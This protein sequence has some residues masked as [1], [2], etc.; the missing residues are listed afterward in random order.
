[1]SYEGLSD[2]ER[3][4]L[5]LI[6]LEI[7]AA[8]LSIFSSLLLI[9]S[10]QRSKREI[11]SGEDDNGGG[12]LGTPTEEAFDAILVSFISTLLFAG[13]SFCRLDMICSDI[14]SGKCDQSLWPNLAISL[15]FVYSLIGQVLKYD[16]VV[17]RMEE[18]ESITVL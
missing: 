1:M 3:E 14:L 6:D 16:G 15:G 7:V 5:R 11:L 8:L 17:G 13:V 9:D 12:A 10:G 2:E 18:Q 4:T